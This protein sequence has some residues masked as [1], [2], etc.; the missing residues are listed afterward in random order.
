VSKLK[1]ENPSQTKEEFKK[2]FGSVVDEIHASFRNMSE[3]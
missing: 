2:V 1:R 3:K